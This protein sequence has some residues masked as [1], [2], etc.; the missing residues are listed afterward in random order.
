MSNNWEVNGVVLNGTGVVL[1][2]GT[3]LGTLVEIQLETFDATVA[4]TVSPDIDTHVQASLVDIEVQTFLAAIEHASVIE[5]SVVDIEVSTHPAT[6]TGIAAVNVIGTTASIELTTFNALI[7]GEEPRVILEGEVK[8]KWGELY[9]LITSTDNRIT[10]GVDNRILKNGWEG[11]FFNLNTRLDGRKR[12]D[13]T[14]GIYYKYRAFWKAVNPFVKVGGNWNPT[15]AVYVK[16]EG[17]WRRV[18]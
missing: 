18:D 13:T 12:D 14:F 9:N 1:E 2:G 10:E 8:S 4:F 6:I 17:L 5:A 11:Y 7:Q 3:I 16:H 15:R